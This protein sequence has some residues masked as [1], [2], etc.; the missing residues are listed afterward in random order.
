MRV[1]GLGFKVGPLAL[2]NQDVC[3]AHAVHVGRGRREPWYR[4]LW[5]RVEGLEFR[6][7]SLGFG[8]GVGGWGFRVLGF[9]FRGQGSEFRVQGSGF[10]VQGSGFRVQGIP[11]AQRR[12][13]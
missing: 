11:G 1:E 5:L 9:R 7:W 13:A 8:V 6:V 3:G 12:T 2:C 10:R 4:V